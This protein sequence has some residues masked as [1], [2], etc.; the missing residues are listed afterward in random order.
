MTAGNQVYIKW[1]VP[2]A[3][4]SL[5]SRIFSNN[6]TYC[7]PDRTF[8]ANMSNKINGHADNYKLDSRYSNLTTAHAGCVWTIEITAE[9]NA[10]NN[11]GIT[12]KN[13]TKQIHITYGIDNPG[14]TFSA[15]AG[16]PSTVVDNETIITNMTQVGYSWSSSNVHQVTSTFTSTNPT[17]C[18]F[19][20]WSAF[21]S[22]SAPKTLAVT[23]SDGFRYLGNSA[24]ALKKA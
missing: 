21:G 9:Q 12:Y 7:G 17:V 14:L 20:P 1:N 2:D 19:G 15:S 11:A 22:S 18:G 8:V 6:T 5:V 23:G 13:V 3:T 16:T 4:Q 10:D 24:A